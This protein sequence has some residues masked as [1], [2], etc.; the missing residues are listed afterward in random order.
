MSKINI[1]NLQGCKRNKIWFQ[2]Q[3]ENNWL[4]L[5][6]PSNEAW[7]DPW[8]IHLESQGVRFQFNTSLEKINC[9]KDGTAISSVV[10]SN[11]HTCET[12]TLK[13]EYYVLAMNP[14]STMD[15]LS[16]TPKL[17]ED[18]ELS[19]FKMITRQPEHL[20][21][22]FRIAFMEKI[23]FPDHETVVILVDS[24]WDITLFSQ[25]QIWSKTILLGEINKQKIKSL[26][27]GTACISENSG[28]LYNISMRNAIKSQFIQEIK[29]Q[30]L[31]CR[32][33]DQMNRSANS[34]RALASFEIAEIEVWPT[35][36]FPKNNNGTVYGEQ[37][38]WVNSVGSLQYQPN[39]VTGISNLF[40]AGAHTKTSADLWSMEG[41]VESGNR[42]ADYI[43]L[44]DCNASKGADLTLNQIIPRYLYVL[45]MLD[46]TLY[47]YGLP[48]LV[49]FAWF[50]L[51][52]ILTIIYIFLDRNIITLCAIVVLIVLGMLI[53]FPEY[54]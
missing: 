54:I 45:K 30:I 6:S 48:N 1:L 47:G 11:M 50:M 27:S 35:W 51:L 33:F 20:Q 10:C 8:R 24:E 26:W 32:D 13:A 2:N 22:S 43:I 9:V 36:V 29:H 53:I 49:N 25:D 17:L 37:P 14:F 46:D 12:Q 3:Q 34:G 28:E 41:G 21:I 52:I 40:L 39:T 18:M 15:V 19:K 44:S 7:F 23:N 16:R 42:V 4:V 5:K 38:K 31:R